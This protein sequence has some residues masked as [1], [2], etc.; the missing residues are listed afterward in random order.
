MSKPTDS[1]ESWKRWLESED[2]K[3]QDVVELTRWLADCDELIAKFKEV[4]QAIKRRM[5][6]VV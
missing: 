5:R 2:F 6:E 1:F 3:Q 4:R